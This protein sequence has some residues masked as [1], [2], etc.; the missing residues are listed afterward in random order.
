MSFWH[1]GARFAG[2]FALFAGLV[3]GAATPGF[4]ERRAIVTEGADYFG[5][6]IETIKDVSVEQCEAACV[7]DNACKAFTYNVKAGWCFKKADFG[8]L[9]TFPGAISGRIV[10]GP[11]AGP[12]LETVR[13]AELDFVGDSDRDLARTLVSTIG[14]LQVDGTLDDITAEASRL[15]M[16]GNLAAA[17][18]LYRSAL[19]FAPERFD[20]WEALANMSLKAGADDYSTRWQLQQDGRAAAV[21]AYLRAIDDN[22]RVR[23]LDLL[24]TAYERSEDWRTAIKAA[25]ARVAV[26]TTAEADKRLADLVAQHGFRVTDNSVDTESA[27]PRICVS[28]SDPILWQLPNIAD[29]VSVA[30]GDGL[31]IEAESGQICASGVEFGKRYAMTVR[32]GL[33]SADGAEVLSRSITTEFYIRDRDASVRFVGK[34]YV[35]PRHEQATI[36]A[37]SVNADRI[38]AQV[39][40]IGDRNL[41]SV[42]DGY[43]FLNMM[44]EW[45][46]DDIAAQRGEQVW[47]G[48][49]D[50]RRQTNREVTTAIPVGEVV[51]DLEPG[52]Y[53]MIA[54]VADAGDQ[55]GDLATQWFIVTD[56]GMRTMSGNDGLHVVLRSLGTA[57]PV[58]GATVEL[59]AKNN[60]LLG[61]VVT[62]ADG[63]AR[64]DPG[65][66][67]GTGGNTPAFVSAR[68]AT[69]F[70]FIDLSTPGFDLTDRG[71]SGRAPPMPVDVFATTERGIYRPGERVHLTALTRDG[72]ADAIADLPL[73]VIVTRPDGAEFLRQTAPDEGAG[74]RTADF[75]LP[76]G[77]MRGSWTAAVHTDPEAAALASVS[78][79]VEDFLPERIDFDFDPGDEPLE[80]GGMRDVTVTANWLYGA[81]ATNLA[82]EGEVYVT[83]AEGIPSAPGW[84]FG[85]EDEEFSPVAEPVSASPTD[86]TGTSVVTLLVPDVYDSTL[87]LTAAVHVRVLDTNGRPVERRRQVAVTNMR[88]RIGIRPGFD[89]FVREGSDASLEIA[90]F[91]ADGERAPATGLSWT[92]SRIDVHYQWYRDGGSWSYRMLETTARTAAGT[93]DVAADGTAPITARVD[94]GQY[95]LEVEDPSGEFIPVSYR[96]NAGWYVPP[97]AD[98]APDI[99]EVT[100]DK[101]GYA[102]GDTLTARILPRFPGTAVVS[103]VDDRL[104][105]MQVVEV[106]EDGG[107]ASFRVTGDWGPGAYVTAEL[108]R[109]LD[110]PA[111]RMPQR[112][113]GLAWAGVDPGDRKLDVAIDVAAEVRPSGPLPI[114]VSVPN[115]A[116]GETAFVTIAAV[117]A[118]ILNLTG[119]EPPAPENWYFAQRR[120][121]MEIR[122]LYGRLI[123]TTIGT[124]GEVRSGGDGAGIARLVGPPPTETLVAFF[125]GVTEVG[126]DGKVRATF[127]LPDF[128]GTVRVMAVAWTAAGVGHGSTDVLVRDPV[129]VQ[130]ALPNFLAPGD[131]SRLRLDLTHVTGPSGDFRLSVSAA[132]SLVRVDPSFADRLVTI[133]DRS[134]ATLLVPLDADAVGDETL[135]VALTV[136]GG[137]V[138]TRTLTMPV[139]ANEPPTVRLSDLELA[140]NGGT[141]TVD[142]DLLAD[143]VPGTAAATVSVGTLAGIDLPGLVRSLDKYPYGCA[144]QI[145]SRALPLVYLDDVVLAAGLDDSTPVR[146]RVQKA[147][148][149]VLQNQ[150]PNGSFGLW[151]PDYD[152]DTWISAY[153][154]DFLTRAKEK[155]YDVPVVALEL[156]VTNLKN[157][158]AYAQDFTDGGEAVA[159]GLYVLARNGRAAIGDL[160]YY[161][162]VKLDAFSTPLAKAQIGA[163]LALYGDTASAD[164]AF[165]AAYESLRAKSGGNGWRQDYGSVLRDGAAIVTL[166]AETRAASADLDYLAATVGELSRATSRP[167]TQEQAWMLL[168]AN[169]LLNDGRRPSL[170]V[171][172]TARDGVYVGRFDEADLSAGSVVLRN[173]AGWPSEARVTVAGVPVTPDPAGGNGYS[174]ERRAYDLEGNEV[175]LSAPVALGQRLVMVVT[176]APDSGVNARLMIDDALPA[177][178]VIDNPNLLSGADV[179]ALDWLGLEPQSTASEFRAD[180]FL[181]AMDRSGSGAFSVGYM[182]RAVAPGDFAWPAAI[183]E[184]M[185]RP[186][187]RARTGSGRLVV[188]GPLR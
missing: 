16:D 186:Y 166:V 77:A 92:L 9:R 69:D 60:E 32:Q 35:L 165:R 169:S 120:L 41:V 63:Y 40:R 152:G 115:A 39:V 159:Y 104:I 102:V 70:A 85:L 158:L 185:Y 15:A 168:A 138:L 26:A 137:E 21:N 56:I 68:A 161:S 179:A 43:S 177:G 130:A 154:T 78:F 121:G 132:G 114:E 8:D 156:A 61:S 151:R 29:Y 55:W 72:K 19:R 163:A 131:R 147:I 96:F 97:T 174:I 10:D 117:D 139:R 105:D 101:S 160:R 79:L 134:S 17:A 173:R 135:T 4:A 7:A 18:G 142:R 136:P 103:V 157:R 145:T 119:F 81:P 90:A 100:L 116:P 30:G 162:E 54:K 111:G 67:R 110:L 87:P 88:P 112:A 52:V 36:P 149:S 27:I 89:G 178:F 184:D 155:D 28:F 99:L 86:E 84:R 48:T 23:A 38:D 167:S 49:V 6:D 98:P 44:A 25:R 123:D 31:S 57:G 62:D 42:L 106:G 128:N 76:A 47:K 64:F 126:A 37:V 24:V 53:A 176:V 95:R 148:E 140:A 133:A 2:T 73:T 1:R 51:R 59:V 82:I 12:D 91:G 83:K 150:A 14:T 181:T 125:Q 188:E 175:D 113:L 93:V 183:V 66:L 5:R 129:V 34:A 118:G 180:R 172:G 58:A 45:Q 13:L 46:A 109:P 146:E 107:S 65:L 143:F 20:L 75:D 144:E 171:N 74:G 122:D 187:M 127:D 153:V 182:V 3:A 50:V 33:P 141:L 80:A 164:R 11:V 22:E 124:R 71:V 108:I 94:W 170:E